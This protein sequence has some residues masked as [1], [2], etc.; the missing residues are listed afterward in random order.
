MELILNF[1]W[2]LLAVMGICL[3][4]RLDRRK[5]AERYVPIVALL[6]L[7]IILF[8]VISVSDDLWSIQNPAETDTVQRRDQFASSPHSIL[9]VLA[10]LCEPGLEMSFGFGNWAPRASITLPAPSA[11]PSARIQNRPPPAA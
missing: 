2:G 3:W 1:A 4:V 8:P 11:P 10:A 6:M 9:P 7:I 5:G